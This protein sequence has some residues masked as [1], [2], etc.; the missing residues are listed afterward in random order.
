MNKFTAN[1]VNGSLSITVHDQH[2]K[3]PVSPAGSF[4][5]FIRSLIEWSPPFP[6]TWRARASVLFPPSLS[7]HLKAHEPGELR[8]KTRHSEYSLKVNAHGSSARQNFTCAKKLERQHFWS[9]DYAK[10]RHFKTSHCSLSF[11]WDKLK[12][13]Q[14]S[15]PF[16][17]EFL[18]NLLS[19]ISHSKKKL[20]R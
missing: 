9:E 20:L 5:H 1:K 14:I 15:L 11:C 10:W 16:S 19:H 3:I 6:W 2:S 7:T 4:H 18:S 12:T 13:K 17:R 8:Q